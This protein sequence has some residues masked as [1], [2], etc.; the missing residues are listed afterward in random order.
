VGY[1]ESLGSHTYKTVSGV[2]A[3]TDPK[4]GR[5]LHLVINQ[6]IHIPHLDHHLLC[7]MQCRVN[8]VTVDETPKFL[9]SQP[10]DQTHALTLTDPENPPQTISLPFMI[11]GVTSFLNVRNITSDEYHS[12]EYTRI[13]L[14]SE[15]LT[16]DPQTT[17]YEES[18]AAMINYSGNIVHNAVRGP[19]LVINE[20]HSLTVDAADITHDCNFYQVL[21]SH[22]VIS[23]M[24]TS[25]NGQMRSRNTAPIDSLTLAARWMI[26]PERAKQTV[27]QTTQRGVRT[28]LN[29]TLA[30]R[31]PTND[32]MLHYKRLPHPTFTDTMFAGTTSKHGNKCAQVHAT[33]FGWARAYP[34]TRKGKAHK[35]LSLMFHRDG[36]P[37]TMIFDSSK[38]QSMGD[39]KRKL[40][41][42]DCHARQTEPYYPWQQAAEGCIHE[43]KRR[44]SRKMIKTGSPKLLW[45]HCLE[46]EVL[47]RSSTSNDIYMTNGKV[48]EIIMTGSTADISYIS[49]FGWYDWVM[50][51]DNIPTYPDDKLILGRYL[52][53]ATDIGSALTAKILK[54]NGQFVCRSTL[55]HFT[56]DELQCRVHI[57]MRT[58][59]DMSILDTLGPAAVTTD[60]PAEDMTPEYDHYDT[61]ILDSNPDHGDIEVTP[62][63]GDNYV[64][65]NILLPRGEPWS[66]DV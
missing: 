33:S 26:P 16:W 7:P 18:E 61:D 44:T 2:I 30:R 47:I 3:Y 62:E 19:S 49:E 56:S 5:M 57:D 58:S 55:R 41:E 10:T 65:A 24:D 25:P 23:S 29:P 51:R 35:T 1:D 40:Q 22:V 21:Q 34:M 36:V 45:D 60:F 37:P 31:F 27:Q 32:R 39:F 12:G 66:G 11:C 53:P 38:E 9:A 43:L 46:L 48:P 28:C 6:A 63:Y 42:A 15:T 14:T 13:A 64:G 54:S 8:D 20:L 59:F 4:T 50:F 52:G 17:L